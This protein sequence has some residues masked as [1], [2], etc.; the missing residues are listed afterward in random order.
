[1]NSDAYLILGMQESMAWFMNSML[2]KKDCFT[3]NVRIVYLGT[4]IYTYQEIVELLHAY[5]PD[6]SYYTKVL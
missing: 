3:K 4:P 5:I 6:I 2:R 1:M